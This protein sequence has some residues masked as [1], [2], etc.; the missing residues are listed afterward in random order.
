M[1]IR[2]K[3]MEKVPYKDIIEHVAEVSR[4]RMQQ[5]ALRPLPDHIRWRSSRR[6]APLILKR[7]GEQPLE[8]LPAE[9]NKKLRY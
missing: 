4:R 1:T 3:I 9:G 8:R 5:E 6:F 2:E 7:L